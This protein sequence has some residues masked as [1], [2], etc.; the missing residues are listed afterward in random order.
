MLKDIS[1]RTAALFLYHWLTT[2]FFL[3]TLTLLGPVRFAADRARAAGWSAG[4]EKAL[5]LGFIALLIAV[6][7]PLALL[8][9]RKTASAAKPALRLG[10]PAGSLALFLAALGAWLTPGLVAGRAAPGSA[11]NYSLSEFVFG[12]YPET[13]RLLAL[14]AEGYSGVISLLSPAVVPFEPVLLAREKKA[15]EEAGLELIHI[16]MVPWISDNAHVEGRL[17]ELGRRG[18]G[19][20][21]VH[22]YLGKDRV[23]VFRGMLERTLG[24]ARTAGDRASA[25]SLADISSFERGAVTKL[26]KDAYFT[27]YPTD[28]EFLAY[29]LNGN[30]KS[31]VSLLDP[32]NPEDKPWIE[33]ERAVA[34]KY[35]LE[36]ANHPWKKLDAAGRAAA[37]REIRKME[38]PLAAHAFLSR[39]PESGEFIEAYAGK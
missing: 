36:F 37:V 4:A 26:G 28:E 16:P 13:E 2:G 20:Y 9:A 21:Y 25:R 18:P 19:K 30:I 5:V 34:R 1:K 24:G 29:L 35:G 39:A 10:L 38:K 11:E 22:C 17:R 7:A 31:L 3:G 23:N 15:S 14:K 8:L 33:K 12:P 27:P 32:A 6:S